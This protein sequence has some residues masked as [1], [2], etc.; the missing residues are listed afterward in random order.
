MATS[1]PVPKP[2]PVPCWATHI[3]T[4]PY[5]SKFKTHANLGHVKLAVGQ[6]SWF[7]TGTECDITVYELDVERNEY[8]VKWEI[9]RGTQDRDLPWN[10][11]AA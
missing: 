6:K 9:P 1:L 10:G 8:V 4:R 7:D 2:K 5:G 11:A 3:P